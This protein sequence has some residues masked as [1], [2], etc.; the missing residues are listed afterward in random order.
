MIWHHQGGLK[1]E[2]S[3]RAEFKADC[4]NT[5]LLIKNNKI[6]VIEGKVTN[7]HYI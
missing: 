5:N 7:K 3:Y 6:P 1:S 4:T 2:L